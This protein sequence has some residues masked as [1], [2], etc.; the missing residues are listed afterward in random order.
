MVR[1]SKQGERRSKSYKR[2]PA[3]SA[4]TGAKKDNLKVGFKEHANAVTGAPAAQY[5][6]PVQKK[7]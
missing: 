1:I 3:P 2:P 6:I 5:F 7:V 4:K